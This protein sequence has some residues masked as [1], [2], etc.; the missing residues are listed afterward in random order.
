MSLGLGIFLSVVVLLLAWQID[1][2]G[3]WRRV[4]L[5]TGSLVCLGA[6]AGVS[7]FYWDKWVE[8]RRQRSEAGRVQA[9]E[10]R[11]YEGIPLGAA[12]AEVLYRKGAPTQR[13]DDRW[14]YSSQ[15]DETQLGIFWS[16][17]RTVASIDCLSKLS[18]GCEGIA[19]VRIGTDEQSLKDLLGQP[20]RE[21]DPDSDGVKTMLYG[22]DE[23]DVTFQLRRKEVETMSIHD[24]KLIIEVIKRDPEFLALPA[25]GRQ[26]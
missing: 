22:T 21:S 17:D 6:I 1:K 23:S 5:W 24:V 12:E 10:F 8:Q 18:R 7:W 3:A 9:G 16:P 26:K 25:E 14:V 13:K 15:S 4:I 2:R 19:G 20:L 11:E